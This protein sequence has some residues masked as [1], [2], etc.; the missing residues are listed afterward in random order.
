[1]SLVLRLLSNN[2]GLSRGDYSVF[3][4][5]AII[6]IIGLV[7]IIQVEL[8]LELPEET[9]GG[10][11][12]ATPAEAAT[13]AITPTPTPTALPTPQPAEKT[14][15]ELSTIT[16]NFEPFDSETPWGFNSESPGPTVK[17]AKGT[18]VTVTFQNTGVTPHNWAIPELNIRT[19][20]IDPGETATVE[21]TAEKAGTFVYYC[22]VA[23]HKDLGM[24]GK[25]VVE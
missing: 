2:R 9:A 23:G 15:V 16:L 7:V 18:T 17:V 4:I 12:E 3:V 6:A 5:I 19:E 13:S 8:S 20:I 21:F 25:L 24:E 11:V 1:M 14:S 10:I 22:E